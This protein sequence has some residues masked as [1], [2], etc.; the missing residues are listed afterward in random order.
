[1][2][3]EPIAL[4]LA[5][6]LGTRMRSRIPKVLHAVAGRPLLAHVLDACRAAGARPIVVLSRESEA[7]REVLPAGTPVALQDPPR[8]TGDAVRAALE[9]TDRA[10]GAAFVVYGDTPLLRAETL[11]RLR[12]LLAERGAVL[13]L[14]AG[15]V[16]ADNEYGRVVRDGAGDVA[17]IVEARLATPEERALPESNLGAYAVDLAWLRRAVPRLVPNETGEVFLTDLV[18]LAREDGCVV[19]AHATDDAEEGLG[20]NTRIDLAAADALARR[21]IRESHM[22]AG[23]TFVDPD[24][25]S[26]DADVRIDADVVIE[27]GTILEGRTTIGAGSR[28]GP[29][30]ILRDTVVGRG[31]RVEASVLEGATLEDEVRVGPYSHLRPG[32]HLERGVEMGNFGEVKNA[33]LRAG[34][35]MHHFSYIGDADIGARVNIGAGTITLNYDGTTKH[36]TE[37]G[38]DAFIGSDTLLRAPVRVGKGAATGA[39]AVVTKDVPDGMLAV[40]MPARAIKKRTPPKT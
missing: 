21:R 20:V 10:T 35:K 11:A 13:A 1:M 4:V 22:L 33:R 30:A 23:V 18:A 37:V 31:C 34:T 7:A 9:A 17:R 27:R 2:S 14:L 38:D 6:G 32:A 24:S 28:V 12:A 36:R 5:A 25:S 19:A 16:G 26:V 40:G 3:E 39:G 15:R 29:Y 8:G